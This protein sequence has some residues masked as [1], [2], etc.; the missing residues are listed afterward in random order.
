MINEI[1][2][3]IDDINALESFFECITYCSINSKGIECT[4]ACYA[5]HLEN[6]NIFKQIAQMLIKYFYIKY[7]PKYIDNLKIFK[8]D[9]LDILFLIKKRL[10]N[11]SQNN[12]Y[13]RTN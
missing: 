5:K 2:S 10:K 12:Q 4:T 9:E 3:N 7:F 8:S 13:Q 6:I 1:Y 11:N